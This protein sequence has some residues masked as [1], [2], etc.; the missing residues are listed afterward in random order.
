MNR[1]AADAIAK[2]VLYEGY[3]LYPYR[4][5][6]LKNRQ[7]FLF[8][9]IYPR[10]WADASGGS[11]RWWCQTECL[12]RG[13]ANTRATLHVR[14]LQMLERRDASGTWHESIEHDLPIASNTFAELVTPV[15]REFEVPGGTETI[16]G[17]V[18]TRVA[19]TGKLTLAA[20]PL[21]QGIYRLRARVENTSTSGQLE[22]DAAMVRAFASLH[23]LI[24]IEHGHV[25]S[26]ADPPDALRGEAERCDNVGLWPI[27][28]GPQSS[29]D[30]VLASPIILEDH[31][32]TAPESRGD[33][34]DATEMD[35]M[36]ALRVLTL[37]DAE[38]DE[39]RATDPRARAML[40]RTENLTEAQL[41]NLHGARRDSRAPPGSTLAR[42]SRVRLRPRRRSDI[43]DVVLAGREATVE[44]VQRDFENRVHVAVTIDDDPG[45]DLGAQGLPGHRFFFDLEEVEP[46]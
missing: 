11:E 28:V 29:D 37:T 4:A 32:A 40:E 46:L 21:G 20:V 42:G 23:L 14:F 34:F 1:A 8:G 31:P 9:S 33:F 10:S 39:V 15:P 5:S 36:L 45:K 25:L 18:R 12:L 6:A 16:D 22:R 27:L 17:V 2:A 30:T 38:K 7:R 44:S 3:V 43:M 19:L 41:L 35:E 26:L 13:D 24:G